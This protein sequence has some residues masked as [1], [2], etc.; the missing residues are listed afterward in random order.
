ME[1][2]CYH[3][4]RKLDGLMSVNAWS[5]RISGGVRS[6]RPHR[7]GY[8]FHDVW[9]P[10]W[11]GRVTFR[12]YRQAYRKLWKVA[13]FGIQ[14][15]LTFKSACT[16]LSLLWLGQY[17]YRPPRKDVKC[18]FVRVDNYVMRAFLKST[19]CTYFCLSSY[20]SHN[21]VNSRAKNK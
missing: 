16:F 8:Q 2:K 18:T 20:F 12:S 3:D 7:F 6:T 4:R 11:V 19:N 13:P 21:L 9:T 5:V 15:G 10:I 17:S 1:W 14:S